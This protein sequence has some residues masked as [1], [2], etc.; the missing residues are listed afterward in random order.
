MGWIPDKTTFFAR[1]FIN[2]INEKLSSNIYLSLIWWLY[3]IS[4]ELLQNF[5]INYRFLFK[6]L[7][8][9]KERDIIICSFKY[10]AHPVQPEMLFLT[11]KLTIHYKIESRGRKNFTRDKM[12]LF[13]VVCC[14]FY[15]N[16][17][18]ISADLLVSTHFI[19][20]NN[21]SND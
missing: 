17:I 1:D 16:K 18:V 2:E 8:F 15:V 3:L 20:L 10:K 21:H 9:T 14:T 5:K 7:N 4:S 13:L 12:T 6:L 19:P 11:L